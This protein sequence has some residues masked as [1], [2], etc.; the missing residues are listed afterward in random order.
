MFSFTTH[1][2]AQLTALRKNVAVVD[3]YTVT[4]QQKIEKMRA[5][6]E[7]L[8]PNLQGSEGCGISGGT[9]SGILYAWV[10]LT[11]K[12]PEKTYDPVVAFPM[13]SSS[14]SA[15]TALATVAR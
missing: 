8:V 1:P 11:A 9:T 15:G 10:K 6:T 4:S 3:P 14:S 5:Y 2:P 7:L 12:R 13:S